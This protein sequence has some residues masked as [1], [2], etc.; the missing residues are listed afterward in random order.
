MP[1][2]KLLHVVFDYDFELFGIT[3]PAKPFKLAWA[4]NRALDV[5]LV[6]KADL[7][8]T[9]DHEKAFC[10]HVYQTHVSTLRLIRNKPLETAPTAA[11]LVPEL[12][13]LDYFLYRR[14][15]DMLDSKRLQEVLRLIPSV[16]LVSFLPLAA[17][18]NKDLFIF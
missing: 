5:R 4:I 12:P 3:T 16:E 15:V 17:L 2:K 14:G 7:I 11:L 8:V 18:K 1:R 13:H 9:D 6:K 10:Q